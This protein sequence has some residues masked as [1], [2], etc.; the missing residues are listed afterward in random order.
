MKNQGAP[1][2]LC[3]EDF[4]SLEP[5]QWC[6]EE[7]ACKFTPCCK[8]CEALLQSGSTY[9]NGRCKNEARDRRAMPVRG[10]VAEKGGCT[11]AVSLVLI[12]THFMYTYASC[13]CGMSCNRIYLQ[14]SCTAAQLQCSH[15]L[16]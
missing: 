2:E 15:F 7:G 12:S 13:T 11:A 3:G 16:A 6:D 14:P 8:W 5:G 10:I 1:T 4:A 9:L